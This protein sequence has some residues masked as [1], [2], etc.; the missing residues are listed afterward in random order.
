VQFA[1]SASHDRSTFTGGIFRFDLYMD[2]A[3]LA[4][5][6]NFDL[7]MDNAT[8]AAVPNSASHAALIY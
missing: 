4:A 6:P 5:V 1:T 3:T 8:L 7:Y 2:N